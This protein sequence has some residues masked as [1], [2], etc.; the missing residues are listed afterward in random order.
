[1]VA[2]LAPALYM[3]AMLDESASTLRSF[4]VLIQGLKQELGG[5]P[6]YST[7]EKDRITELI[8]L[9]LYKVGTPEWERIFPWDDYPQDA[10]HPA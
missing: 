10:T 7:R 5:K 6:P 9:Y 8:R 1:M 3:Q 2:Q 4:W